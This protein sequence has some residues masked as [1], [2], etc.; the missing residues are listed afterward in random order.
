VGGP[1][2]HSSPFR[3]GFGPWKSS[4]E[5]YQGLVI[6]RRR[7]IAQNVEDIG[8]VVAQIRLDGAKVESRRD[9]YDTVNVD[10]SF[11]L[12]IVSERD[13]PKRS[14][15]LADQEFRRIPP[16]ISAD[17]NNHEICE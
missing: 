14:V 11:R 8:A 10:S 15:A 12:Q 13:G 7:R 9:Q 16:A 2:R 17:V 4:S 3:I 1:Y 5:E 6:P